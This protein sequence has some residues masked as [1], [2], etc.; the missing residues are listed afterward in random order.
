[1]KITKIKYLVYVV[2]FVFGIACLS[3][4]LFTLKTPFEKDI[5]AAYAYVDDSEESEEFDILKSA[6]EAKYGKDINFDIK[7]SF[8]FEDSSSVAYGEVYTYQQLLNGR[9]IV[10]AQFKVAVD[11]NK[12]VK[13]T[14]GYILDTSNVKPY[15]VDKNAAKAAVAAVDGGN[16]LSVD[17]VYYFDSLLIHPAYKVVVDGGDMD[18]IYYV[19]AVDASVLSSKQEEKRVRVNMQLTD[20]NDQKVYLDIDQGDDGIY[21]LSD[22][23]RNIYTYNAN[24][25]SNLTTSMSRYQR[26]S[27]QEGNFEAIAVSIF[28]T[29]VKAYDFYLNKDNIGTVRRG[30]NN[31]NDDTEQTSDDE[32]TLNLLVHF[33]REYD[34]AS[35]T[36]SPAQPNIGY[37]VV[38]DGGST[39]DKI[40]YN[41]GKSVDVIGHEYQHGITN[42]IAGLNYVNESGALDEAFSDMFGALIEGN[43]PNDLFGKFWLVG[44]SAV[45]PGGSYPISLRDMRGGTRGQAYSMEEKKQYYTCPLGGNHKNH[46]NC[47]NNYVHANSTVITRVQYLINSN[48]NSEDFFTR[49]RIGTLWYS[50]LNLLTANSTFK[51]FSIAFLESAITLGYPEKIIDVIKDSLNEVGLPV[52]DTYKAVRY[53]DIDGSIYT[54]RLVENGTRI[55]PISSVEN[56]RYDVTLLGW[57]TEDMPEG[58][59]ISQLDP[60]ED[61]ID[62]YPVYKL[63]M[64]LY[65]YSGNSLVYDITASPEDIMSEIQNKVLSANAPVMPPTNETEFVFA[66]WDNDFSNLHTGDIIH[67]KFDERPRVYYIYYYVNGELYSKIEANYGDFADMQAIELRGYNFDGWYMDAAYIFSVKNAEVLGDV[68]LYAKLTVDSSYETMYTVTQVCVVFGAA[69]FIISGSVLLGLFLRKKPRRRKARK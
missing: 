18:N 67:A 33:G 14:G 52:G 59:V 43:D 5:S 42:E 12:N 35:Y 34:N 68:N 4:F 13:T 26:Y 45:N 55:I 22:S 62:L 48:G 15:I 32:F 8:R 50:T 11:N 57:R 25:S 64:T 53:H 38:G 65:F 44:E 47:D 54:T 37:M 21:Y 51:D 58:E 19:S 24:Y 41:Q 39:R 2:I 63:S 69:A 27:S 9:N 29:A 17:E 20:F 1:M 31:K 40:L 7:N 30:I 66:G 3:F 36:Y 6:I 23:V 49:E 10:G 61:D 60:I 56:D 28:E 46:N 16:I